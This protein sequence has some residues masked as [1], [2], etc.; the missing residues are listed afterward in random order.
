LWDSLCFPVGRRKVK[1]EIA[2]SSLPLSPIAH[3]DSSQ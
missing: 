2:S 1:I 3:P